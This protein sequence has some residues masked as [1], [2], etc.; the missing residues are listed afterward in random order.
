LPADAYAALTPADRAQIIDLTL[1]A[2]ELA[3]DE[4]STVPETAPDSLSAGFDSIFAPLGVE[5]AQRARQDALRTDLDD[6]RACELFKLTING[7]QR[8]PENIRAGFLR[9]LARQ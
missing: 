6:G 3:V 5:E 2:A 7:A 1:H 4:H 9:E 8:L